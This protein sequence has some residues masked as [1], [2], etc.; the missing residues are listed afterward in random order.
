MDAKDFKTLHEIVHAA[1]LKLDRTAWDYLVGGA[2]TETTLRRNRLAIDRLGL[3]PRVLNDVSSVD[4][5]GELLGQQLD[6]PVVLAPIGS[7]QMF[8][9]GGGASAA[10]GSGSSSLRSSTALPMA[11]SARTW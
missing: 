5:S 11:S 3:L 10:R 1:R 8:D 4:T 2:E 7:L 6:L 9:P